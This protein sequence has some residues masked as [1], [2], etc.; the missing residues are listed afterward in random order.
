MEIFPQYQNTPEF[1]NFWELGNGKEMINLSGAKVSLDDFDKYAILYYEADSLGDAAAKETLFKMP[2]AE[3]IQLIQ[4]SSQQPVSTGDDLPENL[5]SMFLQMQEIPAWLNEELLEKGSALCRRAGLSALVVLRDFTLMG[6]YDFANINKPLI[7]TG[8]L[9]KG[10]V[11]RLTDTLNF[12]VNVTRKDG[13]RMNAKGYRLC[14]KTRLIH[15]WSRLTILQKSKDWDT[16]NWGLPINT[17]DMIATYTG[18]SLTFILG[19][20]KLGMVIS[21]EE[22]SGLFHLWKYIGHLIGIPHKYIPNNAKE[23]TEQ[24]YC[25]SAIQPR[26][27][28]DSAF[29][30]K[31]LLNE[32]LES[33]IY[34][35]QYQRKRL[36]YLHICCNWFLLDNVTNERLKIPKVC[37]AAVFPKVIIAFN[38][39]AHHFTNNKKQIE[40][41]DIAQMKVL[42]DYLRTDPR[43]QH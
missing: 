13:L 38:K 32:S 30:A 31:S 40:N 20:K 35:Y 34:K 3:A 18:F 4:K 12:W 5:K 43:K 27:D 9:K 36:R 16:Q 37:F 15:S 1:K 10:A 6:G 24:F 14:A 25:W 39:Y 23:A 26:A 19:L 21:K 17:W 11:K 28:K 22:E 29:L 7:F 42:A 2:Y 33:T 41:G 8:G